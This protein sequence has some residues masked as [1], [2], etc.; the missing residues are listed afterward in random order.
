M[1]SSL[2]LN[3]RAVL[4]RL[5]RV[6]LSLPLREAMGDEVA[7]KIPRRFCAMVTANGVSLPNPKHGIDHWNWSPKTAGSSFVNRSIRT[8]RTS[9]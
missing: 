4:K 5:A 1:T 3:R 7:A 8:R 9:T 6:M 2:Q